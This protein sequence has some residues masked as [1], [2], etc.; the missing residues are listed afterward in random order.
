MHDYRLWLNITG[1]QPFSF[2]FTLS[3]TCF[4]YGNMLAAALTFFR[5]IASHGSWVLTI[6]WG[7]WCVCSLFM[8]NSLLGW[9]EFMLD[10]LSLWLSHSLTLSLSIHL[11]IS[12][13]ATWT[14]KAGPQRTG[15]D[16]CESL[17]AGLPRDHWSSKYFLTAFTGSFT[18]TLHAGTGTQHLAQPAQTFRSGPHL[19]SPKSKCRQ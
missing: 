12:P 4:L 17:F 5:R 15:G 16:C 9:G 2:T 14:V 1:G 10:S 13:R 8:N 11:Q 6:E 19:S 7:Q 3:H 18:L